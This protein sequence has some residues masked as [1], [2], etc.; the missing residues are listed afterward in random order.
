[1]FRS[2]SHIVT[3]VGLSIII[4]MFVFA[5]CG[6]SVEQQKLTTIIQEYDQ[7]VEEYATAVQDKND[8]KIAE[9]ENK[10]KTYMTAWVNTKSEM[11]DAITPQVL[12]ELDHQYQ[13][14]TKKYQGLI[15]T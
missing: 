12:D 9:L 5:G 13:K 2:K 3:A 4:G 1:M 14:I 11:M 15:K 7:V 10:V 6:S 8:S